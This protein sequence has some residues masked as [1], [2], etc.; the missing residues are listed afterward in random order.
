M[1]VASVFAIGLNLS[2]IDEGY[3]TPVFF[4]DGFPDRGAMLRNH[5]LES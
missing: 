3:G 4:L 5:I 2:V 1:T